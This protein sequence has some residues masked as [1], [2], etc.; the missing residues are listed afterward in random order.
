VWR[1][2]VGPR[3]DLHTLLLL[4]S[5]DHRRDVERVSQALRQWHQRDYLTSHIHQIDRQLVGRKGRPIVGEPL[6]QLMRWVEEGCHLAKSWCDLVERE[7]T[8]ATRGNWLLEQMASLRT[9][10]HAA[11]PETEI[12]LRELESP[13][14]PGPLAAAASCLRRTV[15]QLRETL[16]LASGNP[17]TVPL[18]TPSWEWFLLDADNL[19]TALYRRLLW[20]PE[21]PLQDDGQPL[22][23][24]LPLVARVLQEACAQG[25]SLREAF[26]SWLQQQDYR[27]IEQL[28]HASADDLDTAD[29]S[30]R[31]QEA[32]DGSRSALR[33]NLTDTNDAI[34]QAVVDGII[35]PE[36]SEYNATIAAIHPE[37][38]LHFPAQYQKLQHVR[39]ALL[40][41]RRARLDALRRHWQTLQERLAA[42]HIERPVQEKVRTFFIGAFDRE[43]TR[44]V[45]ECLARLTEVIDIG[46]DLAEQWFIS[47]PARN[48]LGEF[49]QVAPGIER[50]LEQARNLQVVAEDI[51]KGRTHA[52]IRFA[53]VPMPR[54]EEAVKAIVAWRRLKQQRSKE[55]DEALSIATLLRYLGFTLDTSIETQVHIEQRG[56]DWLHVRASMSASDFLVKPI[57]QFGSQAQGQ[58]DVICLWERPGADTIAARLRELRLNVH[59]VLLLYLGRLTI[60]QQ[61]D[62]ARTSREQELALAVLDENLLLFLAQERDARLPSFLRC[63]LPLAAVNPYTPFQAGDVP[64]E[65]FF[66]R[67]AMARE[68]QRPAGSCLV[69]GGRQL[70]K[71][72]LLRHVQRQ[73]QHPGREQYAWVE[74][75]KLIFD[76]RAG[77]ATATIWRTLREGFKRAGFLSQEVTTDDPEHIIQHI[78]QAMLDSPGRRVLV[79]LDEADDFLDAD[80]Q[81][82]FRVVTALRELMLATQRRCKVIFAGLHNVQRFQGIPN[83]PLAHYGAPSV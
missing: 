7:H 57:P 68:L 40:V 60:R 70:G 18:A 69:Y 5:E 53:E 35:G 64:P 56:V 8:I 6:Q 21:V 79:M 38:V 36:R 51:Q 52:D 37:H 48:V 81:D 74:D 49:K 83:Q 71:S 45:E 24:A 11:F 26:E 30:R 72:A 4:V 39:E 46:G 33:D 82:D 66:G 47:P 10:V 73:F 29:M 77:R 50:W 23:E 62:I 61:R 15:E 63:A 65:M 43:D 20:L 75:M 78:R 14:Q 27:F 1:H 31:Y 32:L 17:E 59:S 42:S 2:L 80:S 25:R 58:Y 28:L 9:Q 19:D 41:A 76:P 67:D 3:G 54:R 16:S 13:G 44:V 22:P 12:A 55:S 34:E